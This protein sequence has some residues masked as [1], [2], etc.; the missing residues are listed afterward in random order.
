MS[1]TTP[2]DTRP[3]SVLPAFAPLAEFLFDSGAYLDACELHGILCG[4]ICG[5]LIAPNAGWM[6]LL[7]LSAEESRRSELKACVDALFKLS[8]DQLSSF[9]FDFEILL[10]T[11]EAGQDL[12]LISSL[13]KWC[14]NFLLGLGIAESGTRTD[15]KISNDTKEIKKELQEA[16][17]DV[18]SVSRIYNQILQCH[19]EVDEEAFFSLLEHVRVA[20]MLIFTELNGRIRPTQH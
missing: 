9:G 5:G 10:P 2:L 6:H 18:Q 19:E 20:A 13:S 11:A 16:K 4:F 1:Q 15:K 14:E 7:L 12:L 17:E 3:A 8:L